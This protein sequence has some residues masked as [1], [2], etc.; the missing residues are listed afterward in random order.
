MAGGV[1]RL[2][3]LERFD[4]R[5]AGRAAEATLVGNVRC[6]ESGAVGDGNTRCPTVHAASCGVDARGAPMTAVVCTNCGTSVT[7]RAFEVF[8]GTF[9]LRCRR[10]TCGRALG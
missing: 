3:V 8:N 2:T 7:A 5:I 10:P 4:I 1:R 6:G 9:E